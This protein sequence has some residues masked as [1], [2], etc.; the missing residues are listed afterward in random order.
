MPYAIWDMTARRAAVSRVTGALVLARKYAR[1]PR[2]MKP[3][4]ENA[5]L[6]GAASLPQLAMIACKSSPRRE[7]DSFDLHS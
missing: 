7:A 3:Q 4:K 2:G 6:G 1:N 5:I